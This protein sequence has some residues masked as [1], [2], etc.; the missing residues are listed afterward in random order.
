MKLSM[1]IECANYDVQ[2]GRSTFYFRANN[3]QWQRTSPEI[4]LE[5]KLIGWTAYEMAHD[6]WE[7]LIRVPTNDV[8]KIYHSKA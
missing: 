6:S 5:H 7:D 8:Q 3:G 1:A 4:A 2:R